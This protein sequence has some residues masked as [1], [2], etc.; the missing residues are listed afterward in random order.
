MP[1]LQPAAVLWDMDGTLIDSEHY[2]MNSEQHLA[3][4]TGAIWTAEDGMNLIGMSLYDSTRV[5]KQKLGLSEEPELIIENLTDSVI[6]QLGSP[7]PWR[8]GAIELLL[9][10]KSRGIKCALVTMSMRRMALAVAERAGESVFD[11]VVAGDDVTHGKPHPEAYLKAAELLGV[12]IRDCIAFEDSV[13]GLRSAEASE[14]I[15]VGIPNIVQLEQKP[16]RHIW[17]TLEGVTVDHLIDFYKEKRA[18][19]DRK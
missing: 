13:T 3:K 8:P 14:A 2:W 9:E 5:I 1:N 10:L 6:S 16:D 15:A 18:N 11:V 7:M 4:S 19:D 17:Q 12:D